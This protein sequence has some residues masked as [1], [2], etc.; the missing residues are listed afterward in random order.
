MLPAMRHSPWILALLLCACAPSDTRIEDDK[1][2]H[3]E[4]AAPA[5]ADVCADLLPEE[6]LSDPPSA[7]LSGPGVRILAFGD[8]GEQP[9]RNQGPQRDVARAMAAYH[10]ERPFDFGVVLGDN[11][12]PSGLG[13]E[14]DPRWTSQWERL[15]SPLG[16]RFYA[17]LGNHD[18]RN[19]ASPPAQIA[20][21]RRSAT[22]CLP[23]R[24]FTFTAG[25]V[26]LFAV[27]TTPVDEPEYEEGGS[28]AAQRE[29]L[30]RALAA[31]RARWKVVYGHH[32]VYTNGEHGEPAG[33]IPGV[34][35]YLLPLL[36][37]HKVDVYLSG[38]DHDQEILEPEG[39]VHFIV[40]GAGGR[41]LRRFETDRCQR[42]GSASSH[43]F[44]VLETDITGLTL[45]VS[46]V[47]RADGV[48]Y[49]V[50][51]GPERIEKGAASECR[52]AIQ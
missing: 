28:M 10:A 5:L 35:E 13:S 25:P 12:Y 9:N 29:W 34:R 3:T 8:F 48:P 43:G 20:R 19:A 32:P 21:S 45:N 26:Q 33:S 24:W 50:A 31:S 37:K 52:A 36:L 39:G 49:K 2:V 1:E 41:H 51:W 14:T 30:D 11:F 27:D 16:I 18:Y 23:R 4:P 6:S 38:H 17:V 15:Y 22:W 46:F 7:P 40:S 44:T 47:E 42:W